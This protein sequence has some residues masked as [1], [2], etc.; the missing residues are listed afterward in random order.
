M[1]RM[2]IVG[3]D[4][5]RASE[6]ALAWAV[7]RE[8]EGGGATG[9]IVVVTAVERTRAD[10]RHPGA[11]PSLQD[12]R[13][14]VEERVSRAAREDPGLR[15]RG[16][17]LTGSPEDVLSRWSAPGT[18]VVVGGAGVSRSRL[19]RR[20]PIGERLATRS[21]RAVAVIPAD[22]DPAEGIGGGIVVGVDG[23]R[24]SHAALRF[25]EHEAE[26]DHV[27]VAAVHVWTEPYVWDQIYV[28]AD[29]LREIVRMQHRDLLEDAVV[30]ASDETPD[31]PVERRAV[32]GHPYFALVRESAGA[33]MLV[34]GSHSHGSLVRRLLGSVSATLVAM[35]PLPV[36]VVHPTAPVRAGLS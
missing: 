10:V 13:A 22:W 24:S 23:T 8:R 3:W 20:M 36:V 6:A 28:P 19:R 32:A 21:C 29:E 27:G 17:A 2:A 14:A 4:G 9:E 30:E 12:A 25:G 16:E 18:L 11:A 5:S 31:V 7:A 35:A 1:T 33:R 15:I 26:R 34:V